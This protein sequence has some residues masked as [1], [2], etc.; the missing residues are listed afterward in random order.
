MTWRYLTQE[1][2]PAVLALCRSNP[3]YYRY[4]QEEPSLSG[5]LDGIF[6]PLPPGKTYADKFVTGFFENGRLAAMMDLITG[7]PDA[8]TAFLGLFMVDAAFQ[9]R[10]VGR[11]LVADVLAGLKEA[12]FSA[13][14][15][16]RVRGNPQ[17]EH[18]WAL[19]GFR[20][21][22]LEIP[23]ERYTVVVMEHTL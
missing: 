9:G 19:C 13:V 21:T 18:F 1:D 3:L 5:V 17:P 7:Y 4:L 22:G 6:R 23:Q 20:P 8:Q 15:L 14:R 2:A 16:C 10:G 12:G 11:K